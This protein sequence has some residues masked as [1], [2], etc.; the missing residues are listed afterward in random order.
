ME[1]KLLKELESLTRK[2]ASADGD[3]FD[4][5][6]GYKSFYISKQ[7]FKS[8]PEASERLKIAFIDG[9]NAEVLRSQNFSYQ[10][11]RT[12]GCVYENSRLSKN[13][14]NSFFLLASA[15]SKDGKIWFKGSLS[16]TDLVQE[17]LLLTDSDN[18]LLKEGPFRARISKIGEIARR[19]AE[20]NAAKK[21]VESKGCDA[22]VLDGTL[23]ATLPKE[24]ELLNGLYGAAEK[25]NV[26]VCA[27]AKSTNIFTNSGASAVNVLNKIGPKSTWVYHP[28]ADI[29]VDSHKA[30]IYFLKLHERSRHIFR[31]E[32]LK[33]QN[34]IEIISSLKNLS[35][36]PVFLGYPYPL[37]QADKFARISNQ[38]KDLMK[39]K[40]L[41]KQPW[42]EEHLSSA[43]VHD[44]LDSM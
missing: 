11:V 3:S 20:I 14:V 29:S 21:I 40:V 16:D 30:D 18:E 42:I 9:G 2:D 13:Q 38:E 25:N 27:L 44:I 24:K 5:P 34:P 19:F 37:I 28:V 31:F 1:E 8:I 32:V 7:S 15:E 39:T 33:G 41:A 4:F 36:D 43:D 26:I 6:E 10:M 23:Q 12:C 17:S 35:K 22:V